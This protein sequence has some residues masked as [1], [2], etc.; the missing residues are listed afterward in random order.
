ML[1][2]VGKRKD[3]KKFAEAKT[4]KNPVMSS[5]MAVGQLH[6]GWI[7]YDNALATHFAAFIKR[8]VTSSTCPFLAKIMYG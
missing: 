5:I 2:G 6:Y 8:Y 7:S 3:D 1:L 4:T